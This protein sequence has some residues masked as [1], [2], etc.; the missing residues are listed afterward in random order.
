MTFLED[1]LNKF[2]IAL[3]ARHG[4]LP[5]HVFVGELDAVLLIFLVSPFFPNVFVPKLQ[6]RK[7][8]R[9]FAIT[10]KYWNSNLPG[11]QLLIPYSI[12]D[13]WLTIPSQLS[14]VLFR[15]ALFCFVFSGSFEKHK[16]KPLVG[17]RYC[18][19]SLKDFNQQSG[20]RPK[21]FNVWQPLTYK[22]QSEGGH[23]Y[24]AP[25]LDLRWR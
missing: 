11:I 4:P 23:D 18:R 7:S 22:V 9:G 1:K 16:K 25:F 2:V 8:L 10:S 15:F 13:M 19:H 6:L 12:E 17:Y 20:Y 14:F 21:Y 3:R 24:I 5:I